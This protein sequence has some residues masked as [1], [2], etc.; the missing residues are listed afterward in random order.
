MLEEAQVK[1][2]FL[3]TTHLA[4]KDLK[5]ILGMIWAIIL[6]Y[7]IKGISVEEMT[8]KEG[9]LLWC[10]KKTAGYRDVKV[11]NF[12]TSWQTGL[13]FCALIHRHRP[14]LLDYDS[15][16]AGDAARNLELAFAVAEKEFGIP[17]LLDVEDIVGVARP[18]ERSIMTYVSEYFHYFSGFDLKEKSGRRIQKF[19]QFNQSMEKMER[20][21]EGQ[22]GH[23]LEWIN[24]TVEKF[25][26]D[27]GFG[28]T[29]SEAKQSFEEQKVFLSKVK[30]QKAGEKL[31]LEAL[32]AN[33]QT[34]LTVYDRAPYAVP[35]GLSPEDIDAAWDR[36]E[37]AERQRGKAIRENLF[38]FISKDTSTIS[39]DQLREFEASFA[40]F[41]K[42]GSGMLDKLEFKAAL[43]ALSIGFKDEAA[44]NALFNKVAE[45][46]SKISRAQFVNYLVE[47]YEDKDTPDQIKEAFAMLSNQSNTINST[48]LRVPPLVDSEIAYLTDRM[49][50]ASTGNY[51]Y[52]QYIN[53]SFQS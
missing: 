28:Q 26:N 10:Q 46:N 47:L 9:L 25:S 38:K 35:S 43:S 39:E 30:P 13:A 22:G 8:A 48:Q 37:Q 21:Y 16:S 19:V 50:A 15:L 42:D 24:S 14:D 3:K 40:H 23:L 5:M 17:R 29:A 6:D 49:P 7:Q 52:V 33:I 45:G 4:D 51:N 18:D 32:Y 1:T 2:N 34:K 27:T 11:E 12:T 44:F 53:Q 20:D 41:D 31:D 36:L